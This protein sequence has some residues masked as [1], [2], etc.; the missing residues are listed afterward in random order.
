MFTLSQQSFDPEHQSSMTR[1][2][3]D[4]DD[5]FRA[6]CWFFFFNLIPTW[7]LYSYIAWIWTRVTLFKD[8]LPTRQRWRLSDVNDQ[9]N[10]S[11]YFRS[12]LT[13]SLSIPS[14]LPIF[15]LHISKLFITFSRSL[16]YL[17]PPLP[18]LSWPM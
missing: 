8:M 10:T 6:F 11:L 12:L 5:I 2:K 9:L 17:P 15:D 16:C 14:I 4:V 18:L 7:I 3:N 1:M 13:L